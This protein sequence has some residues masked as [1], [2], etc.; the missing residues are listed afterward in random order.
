V[1]ARVHGVAAAAGCQLVSMCDLAVAVPE[2]KFA[3]SGIHNGLF[4]STPAVGV[5]RNINRKRAMEMLVTGDLIDADTARAWGLVN[6]VVPA[7]ALD[8]EVAKF[9]AAI[10]AKSGAAIA[11]GKGA[12]Y[13]QVDLGLADAYALA[14][15]TM[16]CNLQS[17]DGIEGVDAF[18]TKRK[19][20]WQGK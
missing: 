7:D 5:A 6:R 4:C 9:T 14:G 2:A 19:A 17:A 16:T 1:I 11:M 15:R 13:Q 8:A 10:C 3:L 18:V 12:F 20:V